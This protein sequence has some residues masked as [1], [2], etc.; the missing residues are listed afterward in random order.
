MGQT[1][2][3]ADLLNPQVLADYVDA[4]LINNIVFAPLAT[5]DNTLVGNPGDT[6][7]VPVYNYIGD[8]EDLTE[9]SAISTV[10][11]T[12]SAASVT[13]KEAGKGVEISDTAILS[14][15]GDPIA[16]IGDQLL[17]SIASTQDVDFLTVMTSN[18]A[19]TMTFTAQ[20]SASTAAIGVQ[21]ISDA[22]ELFGEDI[23]GQKAVVISPKLY[24]KI[25]NV[26]DWAPASEVAAGA[27]VRGA[28][29]QIFGC[30]VMVSNRLRGVGTGLD[31]NAFIVKPGALRLILKRNALAERDR[32]ILRRVWVYT[33]TKH[34]V[35]Y[36][37]N[38]SG[39]IKIVPKGE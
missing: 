14:A 2:K 34:Y 30:D 22:L 32:D 11:L 12:Y 26:K 3:L 28:V 13:V 35:P 23:E 16:E 31:E 38:Q 6:L 15:Y 29:G 1:T 36:L 17:K 39:L 21:D 20:S 9:A 25:R 37:Y 7:T 24:T 5:I 18:A 4:K 27:L 33:I 8:A 19:S 10:K